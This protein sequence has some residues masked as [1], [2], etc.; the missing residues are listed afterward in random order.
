MAGTHSSDTWGYHMV[1][2]GWK[3]EKSH[4][5][6]ESLL[7]GAAVLPYSGN[8]VALRASVWDQMAQKSPCV[9][10]V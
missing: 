10:L 5:E 6:V 4:L 1:T 3:Q 9:W 2:H 8:P 7:L